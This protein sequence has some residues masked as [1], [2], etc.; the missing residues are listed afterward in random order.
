MWTLFLHK[1]NGYFV[2]FFPVNVMN[3]K[4]QFLRKSQLPPPLRNNLIKNNYG[5]YGHFIDR[6]FLVDKISSFWYFCY[7]PAIIT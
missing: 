6:L 2:I 3:K 1:L 5:V 4:H 7:L